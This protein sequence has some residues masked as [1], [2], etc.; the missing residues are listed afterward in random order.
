MSPVFFFLVLFLLA[1]SPEPQAAGPRVPD[2]VNNP[3]KPAA[4][5]RD[6]GPRSEAE[7]PARADSGFLYTSR[8]KARNTIDRKKGLRVTETAVDTCDGSTRVKAVIRDTSRFAVRDGKLYQWRAGQCVGEV[9]TGGHADVV[10]SWSLSESGVFLPRDLRPRACKDTAEPFRIPAELKG[11]LTISETEQSFELTEEICPPEAY[12]PLI[13]MFLIED[14]SIELS[15][16]SCRQLVFR[17]GDAQEAVLSFAKR[18][19]SLA[20]TFTHQARTCAGME[21]MSQGNGAAVACGEDNPVLAM[22]ACLAATGF[23]GGAPPEAPPMIRM[24]RNPG[25]RSPPGPAPRHAPVL[26]DGQA[27][28]PRPVGKSRTWAAPAHERGIFPFHGRGRFPAG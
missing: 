7:A 11:R 17:N 18:G 4:L 21:L 5:R 26:P 20:T 10:G 2:P 15:E 3:D 24:I 19:D 12:L 28:T 8:F 25:P 6:P 16:H 22:L 14:T 9:M 13:A 27:M 1:A 23:F